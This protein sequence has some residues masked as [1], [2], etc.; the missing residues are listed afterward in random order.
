LADPESK[1]I[2]EEW[3]GKMLKA[4]SSD[5][6]KIGKGKDLRSAEIS[7][8]I[9]FYFLLSLALGFLNGDLEI[10]KRETMKEVQWNYNALLGVV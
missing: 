7:S 5:I 10:Q 9:I 1:R 6:Q 2:F 4:L 8:Q 3:K